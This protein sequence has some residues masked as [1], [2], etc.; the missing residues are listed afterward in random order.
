VTLFKVD[1][2]SSLFGETAFQLTKE[3]ISSLKLIKIS[4]LETKHFKIFKEK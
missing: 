3:I 2:A 4:L 1:R